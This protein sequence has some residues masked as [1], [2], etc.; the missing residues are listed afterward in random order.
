MRL[1]YKNSLLDDLC[2]EIG[3]SATVII[4]S[5]YGGGN[6]YVPS[7][8]NGEHKLKNLIG[9]RAF[10]GLVTAF[11]GQDLFIP[12]NSI[13]TR[14]TR[15]RKVRDLVL[16]GKSTYEISVETGFSRMQILKIRRALEAAKMLPIILTEPLG[17][18]HVD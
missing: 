8:A 16:L 18:R 12:R 7:S 9:A 17:E 15:W 1:D 10:T 4:Y 13:F 3:F 11:S 6:L 2:S 5:W 14:Y